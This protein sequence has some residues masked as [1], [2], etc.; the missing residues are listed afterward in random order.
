MPLPLHAQYIGQF[1]DLPVMNPAQTSFVDFTPN[2]PTSSTLWVAFITVHWFSTNTAHDVK[3]DKQTTVPLGGLGSQV[4]LF[5]DCAAIF[6]LSGYRLEVQFSPG[7]LADNEY[8][9]RGGIGLD[10]EAVVLYT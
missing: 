8:N 2:I 7:C 1:H 3:V 5:G 6:H 4:N 10:I 9:T